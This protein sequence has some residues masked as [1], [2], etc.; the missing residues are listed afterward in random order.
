M[1]TKGEVADS[2]LAFPSTK[3]GRVDL[4]HIEPMLRPMAVAALDEGDADRF[5]LVADNMLRLHIVEAN[6]APL[7]A[8]GIF[9]RS[10]R[11]AYVSPRVKPQLPPRRIAALIE[12]A[13]RA[14]LRAAGEPLPGPGPFVLYRGVSG[15]GTHRRVRGL[16]WTLDLEVAR[17]FAR[18]FDDLADP[19]VYR[20]KAEERDVAFFTSERQEQEM[21]VLLPPTAKPERV[22]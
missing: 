9:E 13:D 7:K 21:L 12:R 4:T 8:R 6:V 10:L 15:R 14:K 11:V 20:I 5:L 17:W 16:S 19:A 3:W 22:D 2:V 18:R 1:T